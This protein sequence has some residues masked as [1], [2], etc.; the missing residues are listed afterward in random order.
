MVRH[1]DSNHLTFFRETTGTGPGLQLQKQVL[2]AAG[3]S[4]ADARRSR[5]RGAVLDR[6]CCSGPAPASGRGGRRI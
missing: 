3:S 5:G 1:E 6:T 2:D 4:I